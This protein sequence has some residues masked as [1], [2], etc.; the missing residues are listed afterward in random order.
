M[1]SNTDP[2]VGSVKSIKTPSPNEGEEI[3]PAI[4]VA[5]T[6]RKYMAPSISG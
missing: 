3:F 1:P 6:L 4:S 5:T 2:D